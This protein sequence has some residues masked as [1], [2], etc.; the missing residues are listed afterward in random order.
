M[1]SPEPH[2]ACREVIAEWSNLPQLVDFAASRH[3]FCNSNSGTGVTYPEDLDEYQ[4]A[5]E[6]IHIPFGWLQVFAFQDVS[7]GYELLVPEHI[8][9]AALAE[10]L[11]AIGLISKAN[12]VQLLATKAKEKFNEAVQEQRR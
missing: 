8:Y 5:V 4:V 11:A 3:G 6:G 9:L 10:A 1:T 2:A 7:F 12:E